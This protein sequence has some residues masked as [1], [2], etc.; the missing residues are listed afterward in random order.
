MIDPHWTLETSAIELILTCY[1][2]ILLVYH[3]TLSYH[4]CTDF[5]PTPPPTPP[6]APPHAYHAMTTRPSSWFH[7]V[8][9]KSQGRPMEA[10]KW[11]YCNMFNS[12]TSLPPSS[13]PSLSIMIKA[14]LEGRLYYAIIPTFTG[15]SGRGL[16]SSQ[17]PG[18]Q[19]QA[20]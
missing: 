12:Y 7:T 5:C 1:F 15:A 6:P 18:Q 8:S 9:D 13:F 3:C 10:W 2:C 17:H 4:V 19:T 20:T 16:R 14:I 11:G